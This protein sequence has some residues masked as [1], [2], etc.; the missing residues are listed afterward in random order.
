MNEESFGFDVPSIAL[1]TRE[2]LAPC[3]ARTMTGEYGTHIGA[4]EA[5]S[6]RDA[7]TPCSYIFCTPG[8]IENPLIPRSLKYSLPWRTQLHMSRNHF[9]SDRNQ[10]GSSQIQPCLLPKLPS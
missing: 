8:C 10:S 4:R 1:P 5:Y 9:T 2:S 6:E 3:G 7:E